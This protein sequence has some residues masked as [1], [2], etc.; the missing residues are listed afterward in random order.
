MDLITDISETDLVGIKPVAESGQFAIYAC[1]GENY[2]LV[3]RHESCAWTGVRI[4]GDAVFR[5]G[6][7]LAEAGRDLYHDVAH[8]LSPES[9]P[10]PT[11]ESRIVDA[12]PARDGA[13]ER[14]DLYEDDLTEER[15]ITPVQRDIISAN[16]RLDPDVVS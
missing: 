2:L 11:Y 13:H 16:L 5:V 4:S 7:L 10:H 1:G 14:Y 12:P 8:R 9:R 15:M 6:M 3:Q